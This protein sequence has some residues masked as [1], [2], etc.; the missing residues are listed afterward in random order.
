MTRLPV[1]FLPLAAVLAG[2]LPFQAQAQSIDYGN[3]SQGSDTSGA[4]SSDNSGDGSSSRS[5]R[6]RKASARYKDIEPYIEVAQIVKGEISPRDEVLTYSRVAVGID[7]IVTNRNSGGAVS[8]RYE[9]DFSWQKE[10]GDEDY[11]SGIANGYVE[12][13]PGV[14]LQAGGLAARY[15]VD[16]A[17]RVFDGEVAIQDTVSQVYSVYAGPSITTYAGDVEIKANYR[18]GYTKVETSD[19]FRLDA[20]DQPFDKFDDSVV[21]AA[22]VSAGLKPGTVLPVGVGVAGSIYREDISDLDQRVEDMQ[23]RATTMVPVTHSAAITG[24][25]G[26]E[27]VQISSRDALRDADGE[28]VRRVDGDYVTDKSTPRKLAYD[29]DGLIWDVGVMWRPST[30]TALTASVGRRYGSTSFNGSLTYAPNP[31]SAMAVV[32]YDNVA[33]FG[34][35]VN[36]VLADLPTDFTAIR[37]PISGN[38]GGCVSSLEAGNCLAGSLGSLRS[39]TFRARG[40]AASYTR[41]MGRLKAGIGGGYD[42]RKFI[43]AEGTVLADVNGLIDEKYWLSGYVDAELNQYSGI[44]TYLYANWIESGGSFGGDENELGASAA[45]YRRLTDH[46]TAKAAIAVD[47]YGYSGDELLDDIWITSA[48]VGVKYTF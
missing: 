2:I 18:A 5:R 33:G 40:V 28:P 4:S 35:Q 36:R 48:L 21:H 29:V 1:K 39:A 13:A 45:Y 44:S 9:R 14:R 15:T 38:I 23:A 32:V 46:F 25:V 24:G 17:G 31:R 26:Y 12:V 47:G 42:R 34:G 8:L 30:R 11:V 43:A 16:D 10:T 37:N 19:A 7:G 20:D 27:K 6:G 41:K 22:D 3:V